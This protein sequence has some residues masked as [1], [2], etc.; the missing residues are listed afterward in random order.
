MGGRRRGAA[1]EG[2]AVDAHA[3]VAGRGRLGGT[4]LVKLDLVDD[5]LEAGP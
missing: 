1:H 2:V 5:D 3:L 4:H